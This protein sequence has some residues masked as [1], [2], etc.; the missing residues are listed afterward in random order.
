MGFERGVCDVLMS[1]PKV[2]VPIVFFVGQGDG[3]VIVSFSRSVVGGV[4]DFL[5]HHPPS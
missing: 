2:A 4:R 1:L 3:K 5:Q